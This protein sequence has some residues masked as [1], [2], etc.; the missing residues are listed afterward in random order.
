MDRENNFH[1]RGHDQVGYTQKINLCPVIGRTQILV[2][3]KS[4][5]S[6]FPGSF[7]P[8]CKPP[9]APGLTPHPPRPFI[10]LS[11]LLSAPGTP[12]M[13]GYLSKVCIFPCCCNANLSTMNAINRYV[14]Y[15]LTRPN[16]MQMKI[17]QVYAYAANKSTLQIAKQRR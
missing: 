9:L 8:S 10:R 12:R 11:P 1:V 4:V 6:M 14:V 16:T 17:R 13:L 2:K 5:K 15:T 7:H 3:L